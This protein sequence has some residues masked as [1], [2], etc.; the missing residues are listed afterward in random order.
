MYMLNPN[1]INGIIKNNPENLKLSVP[2]T[3]LGIWSLFFGLLHGPLKV[4]T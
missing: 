2:E 3:S 4:A 1:F